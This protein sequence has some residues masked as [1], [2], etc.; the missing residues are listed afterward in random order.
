MVGA[1]SNSELGGPTKL[2]GELAQ[3]WEEVLTVET[4]L[5]E[6]RMPSLSTELARVSEELLICLADIGKD[7]KATGIME[8]SRPETPVSDPVTSSFHPSPRVNQSE[9]ESILAL[10]PMAS[11]SHQSP[12]NHRPNQAS[13]PTF[14]SRVPMNI[15]A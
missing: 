15:A 9:R 12:R 14:T 10:D 7:A 4:V 3:V 1:V 5:T 11:L 2:V 6:E 13:T 8:V